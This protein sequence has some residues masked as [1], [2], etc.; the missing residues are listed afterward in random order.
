MYLVIREPQYLSYYH[1]S[2]AVQ[3]L[4]G[5]LEKSLSRTHIVVCVNLQYKLNYLHHVNI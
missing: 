3:L 4:G 5:L 1:G 2:H